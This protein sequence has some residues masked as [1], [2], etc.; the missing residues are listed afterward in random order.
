MLSLLRAFLIFS[1]RKWLEFGGQRGYSRHKFGS[2]P[3]RVFYN[4]LVSVVYTNGFSSSLTIHVLPKPVVWLTPWEINRANKRPAEGKMFYRRH[5]V[6]AQHF[7]LSAT[8]NHCIVWRGDGMWLNVC[9][10]F[11]VSGKHDNPQWQSVVRDSSGKIAVNQLFIC[12][13]LWK[14]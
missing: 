7:R 10:V 6:L 5:H 11:S 13:C 9:A 14:W 1:L 2:S 12:K 8:E 4:E 3:V